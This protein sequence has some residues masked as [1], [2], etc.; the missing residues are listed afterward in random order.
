[1]CFN[2]PVSL[3]T[4]IIVIIGSIRLFLLGH[5]PEAIFLGWTCFM[6]LIEFFLW[7]NQSCNNI[8]K[9]M[10]YLGMIINHLEPIVLWLAILYYNKKLP[11]EVNISMIIFLI[12]MML[13]TKNIL[14]NK[15]EYECTEVTEESN[16]HLHWKWN[17]GDY[18]MIF[19]IYF[20]ICLMILSIY[21]LNKG[22]ISA[23]VS[24][25]SFTISYF[26]YNNEI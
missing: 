8:N 18:Y 26:I 6:Q 11:V 1:M 10:T 13:Y 7:R 22:Y 19:Y 2:A 4:F 24:L 25:I 15:K 12:L 14:N 5:K 3:I 9:R 21:G 17:Y 20:I 16:P 23:L